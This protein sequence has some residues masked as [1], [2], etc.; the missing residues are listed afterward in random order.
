MP[1][2]AGTLEV[3]G[4]EIG[5]A[6]A[7]LEQQLAPEKVVALFSAVGY[8]PPAPVLTAASG[9]IQTARSAA[10]ALPAKIA[11]LAGSIAGGSAEQIAAKGFA[12]AQQIAGV[13]SSL[14]ALGQ[15]LKNAAAGN[16][17]LAQF[18]QA[19][20]RRVLDLL[21]VRYLESTSPTIANV[22]EVLGVIERGFVAPPVGA[23]KAAIRYYR[24]S[25]RPDRIAQ[26]LTN[27][28]ALL[29][30]LYDWGK[31]AWSQAPYTKSR[32]LFERVHELL[33]VEGVHA[34][35]K[36]DGVQPPSLSLHSYA[37]TLNV[38][39]ILAEYA[40]DA[41]G[42]LAFEQKIGAAWKFFLEG[43]AQWKAGV[44]VQVAPPLKVEINPAHVTAGASAAAGFRREPGAPPA[45]VFGHTD[46]SRVQISGIEAR[47][48]ASVA[49][50]GGKLKGEPAI[51]AKLAGGKLIIDTS[52]ASGLL[53]PLTSGV[54][55]ESDFNIALAWKLS[56]GLKF[57]GS[58]ALEVAFPTN[59]TVGPLTIQKTYL[60]AALQ[61][62]NVV[63]ELSGAVL[64]NVGPVAITMD[65]IGLETQWSFP[66]NANGNL[67]PVQVDLAFKPP[68]GLGIWIEASIISGGGFISREPGPPERFSG[69]LGLKLAKISIGAFGILE[70]TASG[71]LSFVVVIG[72]RFTPGIQLGWGIALTGVGGVVGINRRANADAL[73]ERLT[74]GAAANVL[75]ASDPVKNAPVLLGDLNAILPAADG[76][77]IVGPTLQLTWLEIAK[78]DLGI[79]IELPGPSKII[80][81]GSARVEFGGQAGTPPLIQIR[82]DIFG[83]ID[84]VQKLVAF[85]AALVNSKVFQV[86][87]L[88]GEAAFR[89]STGDRPYLVLSIGGFYPGFNPE[90]AV[91]PP[92]QRVAV[93]YSAPGA[94]SYRV[95]LEAYFAITSNTLQVG[96][97]L[98]ASLEA[99]PINAL[100]FV[101]FDALI[102]FK[103]F[104]FKI[105][106]AAGFR[107]R[108]EGFTLAG[109]HFKGTLS[110][111]GPVVLAGSF[112]FEIL[113]FEVSWSGSISIGKKN[114]DVITPVGDLVPLLAPE[115]SKAQNVETI[116]AEDKE[117]VG[118][119]KPSAKPVL[120]PMGQF[121]WR[122]KRAPLDV[123][124]DRF[125]GVNLA[126]PQA[127]VVTS[128]VAGSVVKDWFSPGTFRN[129]SQSESINQSAFDRLQAG[130]QI[131]FTNKRSSEK[132]HTLQLKMLRLPQAVPMMTVYT[133]F[134]A[135]T[136]S[137]VDER[138]G[139]VGVSLGSPA[140]SV[141][142][143]SWTMSGPGGMMQGL[144]QTDAHGRAGQSGGIALPAQ[145]AANLINL[146][147]I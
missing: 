117:T 129:L 49:L 9:A 99:G 75:F 8:V 64:V 61:A 34:Q 17:E 88:T 126:N 107:I 7:P 114:P 15:A 4:R 43:D 19:F 128:T 97:K 55:V 103:P 120:T 85:D 66:E 133:A 118:S 92:L 109:V 98:E 145:D 121:V 67:G 18:A 89:L 110:G 69:A 24:R 41:N 106:I 20:P 127:L 22:L 39:G 86:F 94:I 65:R 42:S 73:R 122:Q 3:L 2:Q 81:I 101:S 134:P 93:S 144:T 10:T 48:G 12:L 102:Q 87:E 45:I 91:L 23:S 68:N 28:Q 33:P 80:L 57:Q 52:N 105:G 31:A 84:F 112:T 58:A 40:H 30:D 111:P 135:A 143:E 44:L 141:K 5:K 147:A 47:A 113:F 136:L 125:E 138:S 95:R 130:L 16:A 132:K 13:V 56:T 90:P 71:R 59:V 32:V 1:A 119:V 74:S 124:L 100:G 137:A 140:I 115:L 70:R 6:L 36:L 50:S 79:L 21:I 139:A 62:A 38:A 26:L 77:F 63:A 60:R 14:T 53:K 46:G 131:G 72:I 51:E 11:D 35:L 54:R 25:L 29:G 96:A 76:I 104:Y 116:G 78:F 142:D 27:P 37:F 108:F 146:G 82:L 83:C 123:T